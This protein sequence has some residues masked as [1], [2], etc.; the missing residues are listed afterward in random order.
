LAAP[1]GT[2]MKF[3]MDLYSGVRD[4]CARHNVAMAGGDTVRGKEL[5]LVVA[6][7]AES[8]GTPLVRTGAKPG[9]ALCI[10]GNVGDAQMGLNILLGRKKTP[11]SLRKYFVSRFFNAAP[12]FKEGEA[13]AAA[14]ASSLMDLSDPLS[15]SISILTNASRVGATVVVDDIPVSAPLKKLGAL[16]PSLLSAGEDYGLLFTI[17]PSKLAAL[18]RKISFRVIGNIRPRTGGVQFYFQNKRIKPNEFFEHFA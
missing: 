10:A 7:G 4:A 5:S 3:L 15:S 13:L 2:K 9:D 11:A 14:G 17:R 1:S 18:R 8:A 16:K 12:R 6:V